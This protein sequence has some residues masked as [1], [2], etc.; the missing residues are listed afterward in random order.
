VDPYSNCGIINIAKK[1]GIVTA[2][3]NQYQG[4]FFPNLVVNLS[5]STPTTTTEIAKMNYPPSS[6][7]LATLKSNLTTSLTKNRPYESQKPPNKSTMIC[8]NA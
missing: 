2:V 4:V 7:Y 3:P 6:T 8:P 5:L 1:D